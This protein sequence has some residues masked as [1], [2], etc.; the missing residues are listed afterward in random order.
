MAIVL[1]CMTSSR[2]D[3]LDNA[4]IRKDDFL[5]FEAI[6]VLFLY[7]GVLK[8]VPAIERLTHGTDLTLVAVSLGIFVAIAICL[9][10]PIPIHP[11]V[12]VYFGLYLFLVGWALVS[13][14]LYG[15]GE[16][17]ASQDRKAD[18]NDLLGHGSTT[19]NHK[20]Q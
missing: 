15:S 16:Y 7:A 1:E 5:S 10:R 20:F 14:G 13:F 8:G 17:A 3:Q 9:E 6:Y 4:L 19:I 11:G 2:D 18:G 12:L